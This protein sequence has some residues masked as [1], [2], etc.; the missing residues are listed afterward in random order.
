MSS[1]SRSTGCIGVSS[2]TEQLLD[3]S[4]P[5]A[6]EQAQT[7]AGAKIRCVVVDHAGLSPLAAGP[8]RRLSGSCSLSI[9]QR[10]PHLSPAI[11]TANDLRAR[12]GE[13]VL[14]RNM[15]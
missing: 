10:D 13:E 1:W 6:V 3:A 11:A 14:R 7:I 12:L 2:D 9:Q 4:T 5:G 15:S 8:P